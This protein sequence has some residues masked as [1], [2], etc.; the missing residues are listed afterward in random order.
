MIIIF[1]S[2]LQKSMEYKAKHYTEAKLNFASLAM[3]KIGENF[4]QKNV[5]KIYLLK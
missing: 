4:F 1:C 3:Q 2:I 5:E